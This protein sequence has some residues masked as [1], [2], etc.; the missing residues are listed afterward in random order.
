MGEAYLDIVSHLLRKK[1]QSSNQKITYTSSD[2]KKKSF[3]G[4]KEV[5]EVNSSETL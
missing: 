5:T 3:P 1:Q 2:H 4:S